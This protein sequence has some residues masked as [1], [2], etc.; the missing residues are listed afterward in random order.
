MRIDTFFLKKKKKLNFNIEYHARVNKH[1]SLWDYLF[2]W[3]RLRIFC[4]MRKKK[5]ISM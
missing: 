2:Y 5:S 4:M 1:A 3:S